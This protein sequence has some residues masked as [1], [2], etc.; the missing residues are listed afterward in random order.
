[1]NPKLIGTLLMICA[2][3]ADIGANFLTKKSNG[4]RHKGYA[5]ATLLSVAVTAIFLG[6]SI[7]YIELSVAY[8]LFGAIG[9][10]VTTILDKAFFGLRIR[11]IG[12]VGIATM[13]GGI[14]LL[15]TA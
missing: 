5:V 13:I 4:F 9:I 15:Q 14:I 6:T 7:R 11:P 10:L 1:M 12:M 2:V 3:I 8:A